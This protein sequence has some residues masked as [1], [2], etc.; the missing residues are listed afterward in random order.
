MSSGVG[1]R[2]G[3]GVVPVSVLAVSS[4]TRLLI[5][6]SVCSL[7]AVRHHP[8]CDIIFIS[9]G[10]FMYLCWGGMHIRV[11]L[12]KFSVKMNHT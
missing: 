2:C 4:Y 8:G 6:L 3:R 10:G 12:K 7:T 5:Q 11:E 1:S 9:T